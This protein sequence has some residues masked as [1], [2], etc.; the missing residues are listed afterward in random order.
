MADEGS[1]WGMAAQMGI[2][3]LGEYMASKSKEQQQAILQRALQEF[4]SISPPAL[5]KV[6][7]EQEG[8]SAMEGVHSDPE[9]IAAQRAALD[10][11]KGVS[12]SGG[13]TLTDRANLNRIRNQ[14]AGQASSG[15]QRIA[16]D[17]G[18]RGMLDSGA[19]LAMQLAG[20]EGSAN[21]ASQEGMDIA[22]MEQKRA[23]DAIMGRGKL[24]GEMRGQDFG[25]QS[26]KAEAKDLIARYNAEARSRAQYHNAGLPQQDYENRLNRARGM[27]GQLGNLASF[28]GD[29]AADQRGFYAGMGATAA[30]GG[31]QYDRYQDTQGYTPPPMVN[32]EGSDEDEWKKWGG[33]Y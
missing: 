24:A 8:P 2:S 22:G 4:G 30:R 27:T 6:V 16:E 21:R 13:L 19:Q 10:A 1:G 12:D 26:R 5:Q 31:K 32:A 15:R 29:Q 23:L 3:A 28:Y 33:S 20:N 9:S 7:A 18:S 14:T 17:M 25:E 11:L